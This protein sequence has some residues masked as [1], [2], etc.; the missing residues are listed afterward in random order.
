MSSKRQQ[1]QKRSRTE[2]HPDQRPS[3]TKRRASA[4]KSPQGLAAWWNA[5]KPVLLFVFGFVAVM[6]VFYAFWATDF[7]KNVVSVPIINTNARI[8]GAI[9]NAIGQNIIIDNDLISSE[10][11][12]ISVKRGCDAIE[13]TVLFVAAILTFPAPLSAKIPGILL[14]IF[15]LQTANLA[16]IVSLYLVGVYAPAA[17]EIMHV[18]VWQALFIL[19]AI[20]CWAV[21]IQWSTARLPPATAGNT[22]AGSESPNT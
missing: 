7:F 9:L 22:A 5:K 16:R 4:P 13:P 17:F 19:L 6:A 20:V 14:G 2:S 8:A 21:W 15:V 3:P 12:T 18:D 11:F 10:Q 1:K